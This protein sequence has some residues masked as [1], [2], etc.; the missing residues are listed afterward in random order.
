LIIKVDAN[1]FT[2]ILRNLLNNA[3]KFTP[4]NGQIIIDSKSEKNTT[5]ITI[6]DTGIGMSKEAIDK[7]NRFKEHYT[8]LGTNN[9]RGTGLGLILCKELIK[10]NKGYI[11][12]QSKVGEGS[13]LSLHFV[14]DKIKI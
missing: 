5:T 3:I 14:T 2:I 10:K 1:H 11:T 13:I 6:K 12:V 8:T 7:I 9:E 4:E